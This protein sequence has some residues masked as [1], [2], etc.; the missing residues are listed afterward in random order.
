MKFWKRQAKPRPVLE[1]P[2]LV[3][4][5][6]ALDASRLTD[7]TAKE[8]AEYLQR[9]QTMHPMTRTE[10]G[11]RLVAQIEQQVSPPPPLSLRPADIIVTALEA[12][13]RQLGI[14]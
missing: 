4:W 12:R 13:R 1:R 3:A 7:D 9:Y 5:A 2:D 14:C 8:A 11:L 10:F 6:A